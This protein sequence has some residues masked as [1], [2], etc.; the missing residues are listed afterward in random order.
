MTYGV[1]PTG[2]VRPSLQTILA[3]IER[4]QRALVSQN[5]DQSA[6]SPLGQINGINARQ[7][8]MAWEALETAYNA[9][10]VDKAEDFLLTALGKLTGTWRGA[11]TKSVVLCTVNLNAGTTLIAGTH[12]ARV[13]GKPNI[14]FTPRENVVAAVSGSIAN[15][16]FEAETPGPIEVA[17]GTLT[18]IA[19]A[20]I[21]WNSVTN[22]NPA[23]PGTIEEQDPEF[24]VKLDEQIATA[25]NQTF[26]AIRSDLL[27]LRH[28]GAQWIESVTIFENV[29]NVVDGE[30]RPPHTFEVL[31]SDDTAL[32]PPDYNDQIAQV[33]WDNKP[34]GILPQGFGAL[35]NA[36]DDLG[37]TRVV[38]FSRASQIPIYVSLTLTTVPGFTAQAAVKDAIVLGGAEA[39]EDAGADVVALYL[40]S[41]AFNVPGVI[42]VPVF[43]LGVTPSPAGTGNIAIGLRQVAAFDVSRIVIT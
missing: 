32:R 6:E 15:V 13:V 43:T 42:D 7:L 26:A 12:F 37:V 41:L 11:A 35:G 14:R 9:F 40:R 22:P 10:D 27:A 36:L 34:A 8:G 39:F 3:D 17:S 20:V 21:G 2:F 31:I 5:L 25:G 16:V 38:S 4:D 33:I 29:L 30:T 28:E 18:V 19:T 1:T 23:T 24:R